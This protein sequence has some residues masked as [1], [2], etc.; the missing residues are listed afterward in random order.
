MIAFTGETG[1]GKSIIIDALMLALGERADINVIRAGE[2]LCDIS[3]IFQVPMHIKL[4][5]WMREHDVELDPEKFIILRRILHAE[6]R[7]RSYI[8]GQFFPLQKVKSLSEM[9][10]HIHCQHHHHNLMQHAK[11]R[12]ILDRFAN[13]DKL[14]H[15]LKQSYDHC[16]QIQYDLAATM[17]KAQQYETQENLQTSIDELTA[18]GLI[19]NEMQL[20]HM[21]Y[22]I[23]HNARDYLIAT[24]YIDH[25]LNGDEKYSVS[26]LLNQILQKL[27][28]LP[29]DSAS[30][31]V[32]VEL[33]TSALI[34]CTEASNEIKT[35]AEQL[36]IN[37]ERLAIIENRL[38]LL[39]QLE[40]KY[41]ANV[42]QLPDYV[43]QLQ[44]Q[45]QDVLQINTSIH[46]LNHDFAQFKQIYIKQAEA[47]RASR[48][49]HAKQLAT[50]ITAQM[51]QL[52][53]PNGYLDIELT[54]L[55]KM[56]PHGLDK[57]EYKICI[58]PGMTVNSLAKVVSGG[59]LS[60]ISLAIEMITAQRNTV[61]TLLFDEVDVGIGGGTSAL[62]GQLLRKLGD[63]RQVFCVTHQPQV[64]ACAQQH[65]LVEKFYDN[66][67]TYTNIRMLQ[68][69]ERIN[70]IARMLGGLTITT[71]TIK[72]AEELLYD[73]FICL[74]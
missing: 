31:K 6:G 69:T 23:Q 72:H 54:A 3:A 70:E 22:Q 11:H 9:L 71:Q 44:N 12:E 35:F 60:R 28:T 17:K 68:P 65:F 47:I 41:Q 52:G 50:A 37:P 36:E 73:S 25:L 51:Q 55:E 30:V 67:N 58:N 40:R 57:V 27:N 63:N 16:Q 43:L 66:L 26:K 56:Q 4:A 29:A 15:D 48:H 38:N 10:V 61:T 64:A 20:L 34:Q 8:N 46:Q 5:T 62:V 19:E 14:L 45:L 42:K 49:V 33:L 13:H 39:H 2:A 7:S 18:A 53:M 21:D 74:P 59:E 32:T 24:Q 1:A